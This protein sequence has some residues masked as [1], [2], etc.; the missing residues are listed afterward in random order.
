MC[1]FASQ[2]YPFT[3]AN[4]VRNKVPRLLLEL[5]DFKIKVIESK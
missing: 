5:R 3:Y 2:L 1:I 4:R